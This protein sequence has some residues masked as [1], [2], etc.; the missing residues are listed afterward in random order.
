[1]RA[2]E[3]TQSH[4]LGRKG[5]EK[6]ECPREPPI[7]L[8][9]SYLLPSASSAATHNPHIVNIFRA[10]L[11]LPVRPVADY[12]YETLAEAQRCFATPMLSAEWSSAFH[13][14]YAERFGYRLWEPGGA[15]LAK[16]RVCR[17]G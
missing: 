14:V 2:A 5:S 13:R 17:S 15:S 4:T 1:M 11:P 16:G 8:I 9:P 3:G 10:S 6:T 12:N 7:C